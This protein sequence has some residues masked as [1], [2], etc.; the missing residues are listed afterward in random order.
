MRGPLVILIDDAAATVHRIRGDMRHLGE[1]GRRA[2][3]GAAIAKERA[4]V[5]LDKAGD[6]LQHVLDKLAARRGKR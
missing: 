5:A 1:L 6:D 2:K 3:V 4:K